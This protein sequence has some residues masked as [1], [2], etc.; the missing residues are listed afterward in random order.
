V[1]DLRDCRM[2]LELA[3]RAAGGDEPA[4]RE[5]YERTCDRLFA[6]LCYQIGNRDEALDVLQET[7]LRAF[8]RLGE[9][10]GD[11]PIEAWLRVI[12]L[13][14]A[15]DWKRTIL[16]RW[17]RTVE[18]TESLVRTAPSE[19]EFSGPRERRELERALATLSPHQR[20]ALL[21]R[22]W[23]GRSFREIA[24]AL[25]C[26]E[27]TARV[28]HARACA[29]MRKALKGGPVRFRAGQPEGQTT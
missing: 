24:E 2:D 12:A 29:R 8:D 9:Y 11:A 23:E 10:R 5:I 28:H 1:N 22:E 6:L 21:L 16:R 14:K 26:K 25:C 13:R 20:A 4:W 3:G 27:G 19:P 18:L 15:I 17:K 7:Y